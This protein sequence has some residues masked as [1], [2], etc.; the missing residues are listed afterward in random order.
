ML[1]TRQSRS[2][3]YQGNDIQNRSDEPKNIN[4]ETVTIN[5]SQGLVTQNNRTMEECLSLPL[6][7]ESL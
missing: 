7:L 1:M 5:L 3:H 4:L 2:I 6:R